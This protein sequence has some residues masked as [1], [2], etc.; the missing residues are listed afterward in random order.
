MSGWVVGTA[1]LAFG[2]PEPLDGVGVE[3]DAAGRIEAGEFV[4][5]EARSVRYDLSRTGVL[6]VMILG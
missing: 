5:D 3:N 1:G 4:E 2:W 6:A